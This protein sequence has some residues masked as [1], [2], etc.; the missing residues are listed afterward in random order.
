MKAARILVVEDELIVAKDIQ[1]RLADLGYQAVGIA[2][3]GVQAIAMAGELGPDLVLIDIRLEGDMDGIQAAEQIHQRFR[4]PVVFLT[5]YS[6]DTTLERARIAEPFGYI[7]KPFQDRELKATIEIALYKH[8][9]EVEIRR[10]NRLYI[11]LSQVNQSVVRARTREEL[12]QEVCRVVVESGQFSLTSI[13]WL[14]PQ[15]KAVRPLAQAGGRHDYVRNIKIYADDRPEGRGPT[16]TAIREGKPRVCNN[17]FEDPCTLPWREAAAQEGI[18]SSAAFPIR[19]KG[20][21]AGA[22]SVYAT[23]LDFFQDKEIALLE[24]AAMDISFGLDHLDAETQR[25]RAEVALLESEDRYRGLF[26][27]SFD[28]LMTL[29]PPSWRFTSGNP[30]TVKMF[31]AKSEEE[32]ISRGPWELSPDRQPDGRASAEKAKEMIETAMREGSHFFEWTHR[33]IDGEEFPATVLFSK[34]Q[35]AGKAFLHATIRDTTAQ[36]VAEE[37]LRQQAMLLDAANEAIY[38]RRLDHT[39]TYW[40][41]GAEQLYGWTRAEA[42]GRKITELG[43]LD[44][45]AFAAAHTATL[46][47]GSWTGEVA[48]ISKEGKERVVFCRWTLLR[49]EQG[50]PKEILAINTDI[51]QKKQL[52]G[53]FLRAQRLEGIGALA[54]GISHDLNNIL[55]PILM[56]APFLRD[57]VSDAESRAMVDTVESCAR[58][59]AEI[60][61]Q[62]LTF[63]RGKPGA[64]VPLPVRHLLRDMEKIIRE[65]FPR[66]ICTRVDTPADLW[67]LLGD[68]T[69]IHQ[70]LM[71]LCVNARDAMPDGGRLTMGAKNVV[72]DA[73]LAAMTPTARPG[74]YVRVSVADT[75]AGIAPENLDRIFDPFFT[76][77]EVGKGTGL[78]LATVLGILRGHEGFVRVDSRLGYGTTFELYFPASPEAQAADTPDRPAP[79]PGG[80]G[81]LILVVDD[82]AAIRNV[83]RSTLERHGYRVIMAAE[84]AEGLAVFSQPRA[85]VRAVLADMM[86]PVMNGPSM[87][88]ALRAIEPRLV[89]VGMTGMAER[90]G[91]RGLENLD[92]SALLM[93]PFSN[94]ELLSALHA[95]LLPSRAT[96]APDGAK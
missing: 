63:A 34:M 72:V 58:R 86:M 89:V 28:A 8:R 51:T 87:I 38:V 62:L 73:A 71:N 60:I 95:T 76:T 47:H 53:Q 14:D 42:L 22:L 35:S 20:E 43:D 52:E 11:V 36:L 2:S 23:E 59:G 64:R 84:G 13:G 15:S 49:D 30:A 9:A 3:E 83:V 12:L 66:E 85:E 19:F 91:V 75:G 45:E 4:L 54:S 32:F 93:K 94:D 56:T 61:K 31:R 25:K 82:E 74:P 81:E 7:L 41:V 18:R 79:P 69:Q 80:Q 50:R 37:R 27:S 77:K 48:K 21:V 39:V 26:E 44:Q 1:N 88:Y 92:L 67:P 57:A 29:E 78:G 90:T 68:A 6:E 17:F 70:T 33:R 10:L 16:G 65:T 96:A 46:E 55:A 5:A 24:E 40:N